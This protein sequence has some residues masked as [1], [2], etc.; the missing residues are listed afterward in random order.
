LQAE[1]ARRASDAE[2]WRPGSVRPILVAGVFLASPSGSAGVAGEPMWGA[3][4]AMRGGRVEAEAVVPGRAADVYRAGYLA[5]RGGP[6]V[7]R[8]LRALE[9][10][11]DVVLLDASGLDHPRGA[12]FALH[13][14]AVLDLP[15]VGVTDRPLVASCTPPGP[16]RGDRSPLVLGDRVVGAILRTRTDARPICVHAAWR[17]DPETACEVVL[18][19]TGPAR[20][21]EPLR[22]ARRLARI[23]RARAEGRAPSPGRP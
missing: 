2:P 4:V 8:A 11:P 18:T 23:E 10:G 9:V 13:V 19:V 12:G 17:T 3:V 1:L 21:P 15:T 20:T 22:A 6:L 16:E 7:E 14:G 5:L